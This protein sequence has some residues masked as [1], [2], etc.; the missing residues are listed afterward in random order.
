MPENFT[1]AQKVLRYNKQLASVS[2]D[3]PDGFR[4][5]N[6]FIGESKEKI[7]Q[8]AKIFYEKYYDDNKRRYLILGSS[9]AVRGT[10]VTGVPFEEAGRLREDTGIFVD[11]FR[12]NKSSSEFLHEV[13][14]EYGGRKKFY[15]DFYMNFVCPLGIVRTNS[16]GNDINC[17]YY[18]S[19][20]LLNRLY[21][22]IA[23]SIGSIITFGIDTSVCFCIGSGKNYRVLNEIN[24]NYGFFKTIVPL[25]HPRY[26]MQYNSRYKKLFSDKYLAAL[27]FKTQR[28]ESEK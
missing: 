27:N 5:V 28:G 20:N 9:P 15:S 13:I 25:E 14:E 2:S 21:G 16:R 17:N 4:S 23:D 10:A 8:V 6:P 12:V 1:F 11:K 22:F 26:I 18:D 3:L 24:D 19:K 7:E